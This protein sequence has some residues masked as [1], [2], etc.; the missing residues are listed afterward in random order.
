MPN[1]SKSR[2]D[3]KEKEKKRKDRKDPLPLLKELPAEEAEATST[4]VDG[5]HSED[6]LAIYVSLLGAKTSSKAME[7]SL[8]AFAS[9]SSAAEGKDSPEEK[10]SNSLSLEDSE[11]D[12]TLSD[13]NEEVAPISRS[14]SP[15]QYVGTLMKPS[16]SRDKLFATAATVSSAKLDSASLPLSHFVVQDGI[17]KDSVQWQKG[18]QERSNQRKG[19]IVNVEAGK[20]AGSPKPLAGSSS[21]SSSSSVSKQATARQ[22]AAELIRIGNTSLSAPLLSASGTGD[23]SLLLQVNQESSSSMT[24]ASAE[25]HASSNE[26]KR[27]ELQ[28]LQGGPIS[29]RHREEEWKAMSLKA[30]QGKKGKART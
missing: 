26:R 7:N 21:S 27:K 6:A 11:D 28:D 25:E 18:L 20:S 23:N 30:V 1:D 5:N 9:L 10:R 3:K 29:E 12:G 15:S 4:D 16:G 8:S 2:R 14:L 22:V 19:K 13:D 17:E 24:H